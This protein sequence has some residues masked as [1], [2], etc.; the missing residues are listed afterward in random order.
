MRIGYEISTDF[1]G[2]SALKNKKCNKIKK[3]N[4]LHPFNLLIE[5]VLVTADV[6][7]A[8]AE[9]QG[10]RPANEGHPRTTWAVLVYRRCISRLHPTRTAGQPIPQHLFDMDILGKAPSFCYRYNITP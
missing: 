6:Q 7:S 1:S 3:K 9:Y 10:L 2:A 4:Q 5:K 8:V